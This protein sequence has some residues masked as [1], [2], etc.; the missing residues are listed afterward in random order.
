MLIPA[1]ILVGAMFFLGSTLSFPHVTGVGA[2]AV[3]QLW[4]A[5]LTPLCLYAFLHHSAEATTTDDGPRRTDLVWCFIG[6]LTLYWL[7]TIYLGYYLSSAAFLLAAMYSAGCSGSAHGWFRRR[8]LAGIRLRD[9]RCLVGSIPPGRAAFRENLGRRM[10]LPDAKANTLMDLLHNLALGFEQVLGLMPLLTITVGVSVGIL[11]GAMP[12]LS[13]SMGVALLVPFT[14]A[15]SPSLALILLTAVYLAA[16]YGGSITAVTINAPGTPAAAVTAID[17]YPLTKAGRPGVGLGVS[18]VASTVGGLVG[19]LILIFC[20]V[21]LARLALTFHPADY[22]ALAIFGLSSVASIGGRRWVKALITALLGLLINTIGVDPISGV[23]RF[24]FGIAQLYDGFSL[25]PALIGLFAISEV[26]L[27]I[28]QQ[29]LTSVRIDQAE[30]GW[31]GFRDY[32]Q[33]KVVILRSSVIG[34]IIGIFP[35]AGATIASFVSYDVAKRLSRKPR[36]FGQ[37]SQEGVAA[38]EAANSSSVGGAL[39]PL[40]T[41][42]IPGSASTAVLIGALMIHDVVPGPRLFEDHPEIIYGLFASLLFANLIML[43]LGLFGSRLWVA[44][45]VVPKQLLYPIILAAAVV[46]SYFVR[47]SM[48]D[49]ASC[50]AFGCLGWVLR[51]NDYPVVPI[52]LGMVLGGVL[53][54]NF[55]Q[56][57]L[58]SDYSDFLSPRNLPQ[59]SRDF[60]ALDSDSC[61]QSGDE[62]TPWTRPH[63]M[64]TTCLYLGWF[65][66]LCSVV[67]GQPTDG[68]ITPVAYSFVDGDSGGLAVAEVN[69]ADGKIRRSRILFQSD[70]CREPLKVRWGADGQTL[71]LTN[72][73][74]KGPHLFLIDADAAEDPTTIELLGAPDDVAVTGDLAIIT[75]EKDFLAVVNVAQRQLVSQEDVTKTFVPPANAPEDVHITRDGRT[76][77]VSFQKD[78]QKG[79]KKGN[80]LA[81]YQLPR[82]GRLVDL[83]LERSR[84]DLH[85][86]DNLK[87]QGPGPEVIYVSDKTNT[88]LV[89]LDLYGAVALADWT[90]A[91]RGR[92]VH[93]ILLSTSPHGRWGTAFPDRG[94]PLLLGDHEYFLV[95]N[96]GQEGGSALVRLKQREIVWRR[97]TPPGLETPIFFPQLRQAFSV[98]SG[99]TKQRASGRVDKSFHPRQSL[100]V[101]DFNSSTAVQTKPVEAVP[102]PAY[103]FQITLVEQQPPRLL[104]AIGSTPEAADRLITYDPV[105]RAILDNQPA[106]GRIGRLQ[107]H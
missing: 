104:L 6:L 16:D 10:T 2:A 83:P 87:E 24:T 20:S 60:G 8:R 59:H 64:R 19:T 45:T 74:S 33:L 36:Q 37:G 18:L 65:L 48:F 56:A 94:C 96:A 93:W 66:L 15:M 27:Q 53:E 47:S 14:Y 42:G 77:V 84:P 105:S 26:F 32:W 46:G 85:I 5:L 25:I 54:E 39:V 98:C 7:G 97:D 107:A 91:R 99:K 31:P 75:G 43:L 38:A 40:L 86:S 72:L 80:R 58:M 61:F 81:I 95:C 23:S 17:G 50:L 103:T 63:S 28:Q 55:R 106:A 11:I 21:P 92:A 35:G 57:V 3:P 78:S 44:V 76:A 62:P 79:K 90:N 13:P 100:Y 67:Q 82:M 34:T 22:F 51:K 89:T 29:H 69:H 88:L 9:V 73:A 12:G 71:I 30:S 49:V 41:L 52:V 102:L 70:R 101:F 1:A 4:I 68:R